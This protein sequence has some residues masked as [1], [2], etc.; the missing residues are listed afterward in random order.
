M[1]GFSVLDMFGLRT[2]F[3]VALVG[4]CTSASMSGMVKISLK[5]SKFHFLVVRMPQGGADWGLRL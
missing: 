2:I 4:G 3:L 5:D 1:T